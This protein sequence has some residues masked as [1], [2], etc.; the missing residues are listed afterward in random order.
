MQEAVRVFGFHEFVVEGLPH[1]GSA[2]AVAGAVNRRLSLRA[3]R[4]NRPRTMYERAA[5]VSFASI[6][7]C[8]R[9]DERL[10]KV[11]D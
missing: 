2:G 3:K 11:T 7:G 1:G 5:R 4:G 9:N 6:A 8:A 10:C